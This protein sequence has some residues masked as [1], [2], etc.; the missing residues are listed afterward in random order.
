LIKIKLTKFTFKTGNSRRYN[1]V[2]RKQVPNV[3]DPI[4]KEVTISSGSNMT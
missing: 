2:T 1:D 4:S 3:D